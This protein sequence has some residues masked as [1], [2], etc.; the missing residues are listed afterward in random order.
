M[1]SNM[2]ELLELIVHL[3]IYIAL[4]FLAI[5]CIITANSLNHESPHIQKTILIA[6]LLSCFTLFICTY[7]SLAH[8]WI[9][10]SVIPLI[11]GAAFGLI[12]SLHTKN[13][14]L[15][16]E[17]KKLTRSELVSMFIQT[18]NREKH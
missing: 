7:Y 11:F 18:F 12:E 15:I 8:T 13:I 4:F 10:L 6:K 17:I 3:F 9:L 14:H 5:V 2:Y 16:V 1:G